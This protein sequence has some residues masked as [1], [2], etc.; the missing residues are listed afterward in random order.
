MIK[1]NAQGGITRAFMYDGNGNATLMMESHATDLRP[2]TIDEIFDR[3]RPQGP[4]DVFQTI[5]L[6]DGRNQVVDVIQPTMNTSDGRWGLPV[7]EVYPLGPGQIGLAVGG[8][9]GGPIGM[10]ALG[11]DDGVIDVMSTGGGPSG[12]SVTGGFTIDSDSKGQLFATLKLTL[13]DFKPAFGSYWLDINAGMKVWIGEI[14]KQL[15]FHTTAV[16]T[17][18]DLTNITVTIPCSN[19]MDLRSKTYATLVDDNFSVVLH[20]N[21]SGK[22][23]DL[24]RAFASQ[25]VQS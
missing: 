14:S 24:G 22:T 18:G 11:K 6:F 12:L 20:S 15:D 10:P 8:P 19:S 25:S 2:L 13:P 3:C 21:S 17:E 9:V 4:G 23:Y 1:G 5:T 7:T 16:I